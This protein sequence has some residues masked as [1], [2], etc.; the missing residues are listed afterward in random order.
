MRNK[1]TP[2]RQS[3]LTYVV[4]DARWRRSSDRRSHG[5]AYEERQLPLEEQRQRL[6]LQSM[7]ERRRRRRHA[8]RRDRWRRRIHTMRMN[9]GGGGFCIPARGGTTEELV[10]PGRGWNRSGELELAHVRQSPECVVSWRDEDGMA[11]PFVA[12]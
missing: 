8:R 2:N 3:S 7:E 12:V 6:N 4:E 1:L 11:D 9:G 5:H 10:R